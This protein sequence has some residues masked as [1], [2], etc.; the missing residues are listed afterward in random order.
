VNGL[1][2]SNCL[3]SC[4]KIGPDDHGK[5]PTSVL[6]CSLPHMT[7]NRMSHF[8]LDSA[9]LKRA[10]FG[11]GLGAYQNLTWKRCHQPS[12]RPD[13]MKKH[14][15]PHLRYWRHPKSNAVP[16][17]GAA[18]QCEARRARKATTL[19]RRGLFQLHLGSTLG[20]GHGDTKLV[21]SGLLPAGLVGQFP[22]P[23]RASNR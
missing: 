12:P 17:D 10:S 15:R 13:S 9:L 8:K 6:H 11:V 22:T 14:F 23:S 3:E 5:H 2:A 1:Q 4:K 20:E 18:A 16:A 19:P 21:W 7:K